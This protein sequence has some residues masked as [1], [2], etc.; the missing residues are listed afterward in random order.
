MKPLLALYFL[1]DVFC[2]SEHQIY[3]VQFALLPVKRLFGRGGLFVRD[4]RRKFISQLFFEFNCPLAYVLASVL[5]TVTPTALFTY[6]AYGPNFRLHR[7]LSVYFTF[8]FLNN[9]Y[10]LSQRE[11]NK[12]QAVVLFPHL[13][14]ELIVLLFQLLSLH[15]LQY[16]R[17]IE[18]FGLLF[19]TSRNPE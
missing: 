12:F 13:L 1:L 4:K 8:D 10:L 11:L 5:D 17:L 15:E 2:R 9:F 19:V 7:C 16:I 18:N 3:V 6:T 14:S